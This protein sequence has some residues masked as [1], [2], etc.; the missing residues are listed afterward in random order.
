MEYPIIAIS[1]ALLALFGIAYFDTNLQIIVQC[2]VALTVIITGWTGKL[3]INHCTWNHF[4]GKK[5]AERFEIGASAVIAMVSHLIWI[6][7][8]LVPKRDHEVRL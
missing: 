1:L 5:I 7:E 3:T 2:R 4:E 6:G 8:F